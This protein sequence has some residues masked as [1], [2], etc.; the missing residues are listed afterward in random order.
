MPEPLDVDPDQLVELDRADLNAIFAYIARIRSLTIVFDHQGKPVS[1][2]PRREQL[3]ALVNAGRALRRV[4]ARSPAERDGAPSSNVQERALPQ[5]YGNNMI[6]PRDWE[7]APATAGWAMHYLQAAGVGFDMA[8]LVQEFVS[9]WRARGKPMA[10][11][12]QA[13]KHNIL[14]KHGRGG[15]LAPARNGNGRLHD[16][17]AELRRQRLDDFDAE[18]RDLA[19]SGTDRPPADGVVGK[20]D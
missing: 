10:N 16:R 12:Q 3:K 17:A 5:L 18:A 7:P 11:W 1:L 14:T 9:Y 2:E 15:S 6:I 13:F 4:P 20:D 19:G 8:W